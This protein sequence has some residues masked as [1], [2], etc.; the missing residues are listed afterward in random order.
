MLLIMR[1]VLIPM[2]LIRVLLLIRML[3]DLMFRIPM[4]IL[5]RM[6]LIRIRTLTY[7]RPIT[8]QPMQ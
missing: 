4:L 1:M 3:L 6:L 7:N 8:M 5:I 2:L